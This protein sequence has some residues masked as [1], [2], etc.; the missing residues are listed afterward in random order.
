[1]K[2]L[3]LTT[4]ATA[5]VA[6]GAFAQG[7]ISQMQIMF[8]ADGITTP[9]PGAQTPG[10]ATT[11][12]T[13]SVALELFYAPSNSTSLANIAAI[14]ALDGTAG[15]GAAALTLLGT[16]G[17]TL[18]SSTNLSTTT[19]GNGV[20]SVVFP[21]S[22]GDFSAADPNQ[23]NLLSPAATSANA[24]IAMYLVGDA[25]DAFNGS[26]GVLAFLQN[27]GGNPYIT[28]AGTPSTMAVDPEGLNIVL[29]PVPEPT[30]IALATLGGASLLLFRRRKA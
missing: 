12:Y 18:V 21:V 3:I 2:K 19:V 28:P 29:E 15:G 27:T 9:G 5:A 11:Y 7:S 20:G 16:D 1:M 10:V 14:N 26:S 24:V 22:G 6:S 17:F 8:V 23:V 25:A 13:G 30:T 4:L